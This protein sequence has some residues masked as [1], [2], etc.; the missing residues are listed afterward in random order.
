MFFTDA[1]L[2]FVIALPKAKTEAFEA[3]HL[4]AKAVHKAGAI[5]YSQML[6]LDA[7]C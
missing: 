6:K 3:I 7:A 2:N 1:K 4:S 5:S